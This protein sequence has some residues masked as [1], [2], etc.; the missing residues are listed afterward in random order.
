MLG[1]L[2]FFS[3]GLCMCMIMMQTSM[4]SAGARALI[5]IKIF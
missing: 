3:S 5:I 2:N 4:I 1:A